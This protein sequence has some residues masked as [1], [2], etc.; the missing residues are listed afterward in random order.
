MT[1]PIA[2]Y[3]I[4]CELYSIADP[5]LFDD[6]F[7]VLDV[8]LAL[9]RMLDFHTLEVVDLASLVTLGL[10]VVDASVG[11]GIHYGNIEYILLFVNLEAECCG[12]AES[13]LDGTVGI[14]DE[15]LVCV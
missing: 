13:T 6:F 7:T 5:K 2:F 1:R 14:G 9:N 4:E 10:D 15:A 3:S 11:L 8:N 12:N